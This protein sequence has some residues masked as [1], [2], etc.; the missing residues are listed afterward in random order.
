MDSDIVHR[1]LLYKL[2][3]TTNLKGR[4]SIKRFLW[5]CGAKRTKESK[6]NGVWLTHIEVRDKNKWFL[7]KIK[8]GL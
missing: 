7:A 2:G 5:H 8:Y 3:Y 6:T 1:D 4:V